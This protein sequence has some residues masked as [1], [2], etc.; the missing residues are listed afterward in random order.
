MIFFTVGNSTTPIYIDSDGKAQSCSSQDIALK[1]D[2][3]DRIYTNDISTSSSGSISIPLLHAEELAKPNRG[4]NIIYSNCS[5]I[6]VCFEIFV[7]ASTSD[8]SVRIF[9][10]D[11]SN[12]A[13]NIVILTNTIF[14][15]YFYRDYG[16]YKIH[17]SFYLSKDTSS[18]YPSQ[19]SYDILSYD[20]YIN[21]IM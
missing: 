21:T 5:K 6:Q 19:V 8:L 13:K 11:Y 16:D 20:D 9:T 4:I 15:K 14:S 3:F 7:D 18:G 1:F 10:V 17:T 12:S 2:P